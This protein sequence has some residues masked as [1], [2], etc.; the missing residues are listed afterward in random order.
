MTAAT[1]RSGVPVI[2]L[3]EQLRAAVGDDAAASVHRGATSQD[4]VDT[5]AM[6]L[7][8]PCRDARCARL[9][10]AVAGVERLASDGGDTPMIGR[11]LGQ[12]ALPTTFAAVTARWRNGL[13]EAST[14]LR[15]LAR[16]LP[17]QLGGPVGDGAS[18]GPHAR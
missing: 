5:A 4:I 7:T 17:V 8:V 11:T 14:A 6:V 1:E 3:V 12:Y 15:Q 9:D 10:D 16:S 18:Y 13:D 2:A